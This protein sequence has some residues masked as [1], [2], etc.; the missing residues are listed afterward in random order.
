MSNFIEEQAELQERGYVHHVT[1]RWK[2][3]LAGEFRSGL[4]VNASSVVAA[5]RIQVK[6]GEGM[7]FGFTV[8]TSKATAQFIQLHDTQTAPG[9]GAVPVAVWQIN[10]AAIATGNDLAVSYIFPG[11]WFDRGCWLV[12][13]S[14]AATLTAGSAD[15]FF[16]AQ[17]I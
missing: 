2:L 3:I 9:S 14:T 7:L 1:Q 16:D 5:N 10:G 13:S 11:R 15:C 6:A 12:N 8:N 17:Y 4:P